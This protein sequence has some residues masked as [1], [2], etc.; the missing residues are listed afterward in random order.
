MG[1]KTNR[2]L[3]AKAE[4]AAKQRREYAMQKY[5][6]PAVRTISQPLHVEGFKIRKLR[7]VPDT[8]VERVRGDGRP[9]RLVGAILTGV[10]P[11]TSWL[12]KA[13]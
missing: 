8:K 12:I 6:P 2:N 13:R 1:T 9:D 4:K 10:N 3:Q 11:G 5:G 7:T